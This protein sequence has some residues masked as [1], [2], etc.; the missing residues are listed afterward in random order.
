MQCC[1][2]AGPSSSMAASVWRTACTSIPHDDDCYT[3]L[4]F[5]INIVGQVE[6]GIVHPPE[7]N[8]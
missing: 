4:I 2:N 6:G 8:F 3:C 1:S 7:I 5:Q